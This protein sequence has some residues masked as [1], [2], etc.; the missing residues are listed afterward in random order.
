[1]PGKEDGL[2]TLGW[3]RGEFKVTRH[4]VTSTAFNAW[5]STNGRHALR[6]AL[7]NTSQRWFLGE[8]RARRRLYE[9]ARNAFRPRGTFADTMKKRADEL[10]AVVRSCALAIRKGAFGHMSTFDSDY[11]L[12][13]VPRALI[14]HDFRMRMLR[15]LSTLPQV[16]LFRGLTEDIISAA[17]MDAEA[18]LFQYLMRHAP[19]ID[20]TGHGLILE[21]DAEFP[22]RLGGSEGHYVFAWTS[23]ERMDLAGRRDRKRFLSAIAEMRDAQSVYLKRMSPADVQ[24]LRTAIDLRRLAGSRAKLQHSAHAKVRIVSEAEELVFSETV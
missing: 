1:M 14:Q 9:D 16:Q 2:G 21:I 5:L 8:T 7:R 24:D 15:E 3:K 20:T 11:C 10:P 4:P 19:L 12:C 23:D 6:E 22:W 17:A 13:V 18:S